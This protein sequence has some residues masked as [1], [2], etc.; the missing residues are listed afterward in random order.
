M[1]KRTFISK[2]NILLKLDYPSGDNIWLTNSFT[3]RRIIGILGMSLPILLYGFLY[4]DSGLLQPLDSISHYYYTRVSS[5]FVT[6]ISVLAIFLMIY[7]GREPIDFYTSLTAGVFALLVVFFPTGNITD[8]CC[9]PAKNYSVTIL[10]V[11]KFRVIFHY[12]SAAMFLIC[13][14]FMSLFLFTNSNQSGEK[15]G[16]RIKVH[17]RIH[18]TC[19]VLMLMALMIILAGYLDIIPDDFYEAH[20]LTFWMETLAV[21]SF[22]FSW[23]LKGNAFFE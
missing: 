4:I 23:L 5:L 20:H 21:E 12:F 13:L 3:L 16:T 22:G 10:P 17:N 7:K 18:R 14:S 11:D 9:D 6:T 2:L 8:V 15:K 19:G 1:M